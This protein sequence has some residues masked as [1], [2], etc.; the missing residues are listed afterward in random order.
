MIELVK[1]Q[2]DWHETINANF[3]ELG[4]KVNV[5]NSNASSAVTIANSAK[6]LAQNAN[7]AVSNI[8][9]D[10]EEYGVATLP[11]FKLAVNG[12]LEALEEG[13]MDFNGW[14]RFLKTGSGGIDK[15]VFMMPFGVFVNGH[16]TRQNSWG[17]IT[18]QVIVYN[19]GNVTT[20]YKYKSSWGYVEGNIFNLQKIGSIF[21]EQSYSFESTGMVHT[22]GVGIKWDGESTTFYDVSTADVL[23]YFVSTI[24]PFNSK[25]FI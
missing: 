25:Y 8:S 3:E 20:D 10:L 13:K 18:E 14:K 16:A 9:D 5:A 7:T 23:Q 19:N 15:S 12:R 1:G 21:I 6:T 17:A 11:D 22:A 2:L 4:G 24:Y